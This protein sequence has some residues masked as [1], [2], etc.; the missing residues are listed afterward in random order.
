MG[1]VAQS[2][3]NHH[4]DFCSLY[5]VRQGRGTHVIDGSSYGVARGDVYAMNPGMT[6]HFAECHDLV[7]DTIH[8]APGIFS[9]DVLTV[10]SNTTGFRSL[11]VGED[12]VT[13]GGR[14]LHLS[15]AAYQ[16]LAE[17]VTEL[18]REWVSGTPDGQL[19]A[20]GLFCAC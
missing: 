20:H 16:E 18:R 13:T 8:F 9:A 11:F 10:L 4:H 7:T 1:D 5:I 12:G 19:L 6:H 15:P 17:M 3:A 2:V 14:W